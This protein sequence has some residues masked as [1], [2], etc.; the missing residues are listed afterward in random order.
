MR[1]RGKGTHHFLQRG[2]AGKGKVGEGVF[3]RLCEVCNV[4]CWSDGGLGHRDGME[5]ETETEVE[6]EGDGCKG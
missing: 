4:V 1:R 6:I 5:M 3:E 2:S